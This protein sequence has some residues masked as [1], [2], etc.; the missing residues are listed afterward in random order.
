MK[1]ARRPS[2]RG[3]ALLTTLLL[4]AVMAMI[5]VA[6]LDD[7]RF[8]IRRASNTESLAQAQLYAVGAEALAKSR[9]ESVLARRSGYVTLQGGWSGLPLVYPIEHGAIHMRLI[10]R[11]ACFNLNSVVSG[12]PD[13]YAVN[14]TG[15]AQ[16]RQLLIAL[17]LPEAEAERLSDALVDW[18]DS[19]SVARPSGAEDEAYR[20]GAPPYRTSGDLLAEETELRAIQG[21]TPEVYD[22]IR[23]FV[24]A[25]PIPQLTVVN[26]NTMLP[27]D[28]PV[29]NAVYLGRLPVESAR[30]VIARRPPDGWPSQT[31]FLQEPLLERSVREEGASPIQQLEIRSRFFVL[32]G[33]VELAGFFLP[34]SGLLEAS[35]S[36]ALVT[37]VRRW[38]AIE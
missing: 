15:A 20:R 6:V 22:K 28:A 29:L 14:P 19:D 25:L 21:F 17:A 7:I 10:D 2:E 11:G 5:A 27:A 26:V 9:L 3:V 18:I 8:A 12:E 32:E 34:Y 37:S 30:Q 35:P 4:V 31:A 16:F 33:T 23:P 24:C 38:A 13:S 36:G 1:K